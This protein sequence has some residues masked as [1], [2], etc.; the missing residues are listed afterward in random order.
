MSRPATPAGVRLRRLRWQITF[1]FALVNAGF[2]IGLTVATERL[3]HQHGEAEMYAEMH[4]RTS[5]AVREIAVRDGRVVENGLVDD[6]LTQGPPGLILLIGTRAPFTVAYRTGH[7]LA[8]LPEPAVRDAAR[9]A[10][11]TMAPAR[12]VV[13]GPDGHRLAVLA[14]AT[15]DDGR[16]DEVSGAVVAVADLAAVEAEHRRFVLVL[17]LVCLVALAGAPAVGY[18]LAGRSLRPAQ[19]ALDDQ[20]AFLADT[21]HDLRTPLAALRAYAQAAIHDPTQR[22]ELLP[23]VVTLSTQLQ[24]TVDQALAQ[25]RLSAGT[26]A[27]DLEPLRLDQLVEDLVDHRPEAAGTVTVRAVPSVVRGDADLLRRAIGNLVDNAL[28]HGRAPGARPEVTVTVEGGTVSVADRGPGVP[29]DVLTRPA[30]RRGLA[31][32][33]R[34]AGL[35]GGTLTATGRDGGATF[36]LTLPTVGGRCGGQR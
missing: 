3:T 7:P 15:Y 4:R 12:L 26:Q 23:R 11:A 28:R 25:A 34:I 32:S 6:D 24:A 20:E 2:A 29:S 18:T 19:R 17:A 21:A 30:T 13:T 27:V 31:I 8:Q 22:A 35:H 9:R 36:T 10:V 33:R 14:E 5:G 1:V 16:P